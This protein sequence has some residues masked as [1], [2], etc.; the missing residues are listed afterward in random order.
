MLRDNRTASAA[1]G[2]AVANR[3]VAGSARVTPCAVERSAPSEAT[4][5]RSSHHDSASTAATHGTSEP[6][7]TNAETSPEPPGSSRELGNRNAAS[8]PRD[9]R[10]QSYATPAR[11]PPRGSGTMPTGS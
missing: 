8:A 11:A 2:P 5:H 4:A 7:A 10:P 6:F 1:R 9:H 3:S